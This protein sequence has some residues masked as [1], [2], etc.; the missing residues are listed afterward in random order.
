MYHVGERICIW[1]GDSVTCGVVVEVDTLSAVTHYEVLMDTDD[2]QSIPA[3]KREQWTVREDDDLW[4]EAEGPSAAMR[5]KIRTWYREVPPELHVW[6]E[7][8]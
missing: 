5:E 1:F 4:R 6:L 3:E 7:K 8:K 2:G